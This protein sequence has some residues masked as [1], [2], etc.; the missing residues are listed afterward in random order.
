MAVVTS[1]ARAEP[2]AASVSASERGRLPRGLVAGLLRTRPGV[3]GAHFK[4]HWSLLGEP[5]GVLIMAIPKRLLARAV[6]RNAVRRVAREAWRASALAQAPVAAVLRMTAV[7]PARGNRHRKA[8]VRAELDAAF[9]AMRKRLAQ[10]RQRRAPDA[11]T[12]P[13]AAAP[14]AAPDAAR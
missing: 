9:G 6:D 3:A 10:P 13:G 7:P 2:R 14:G 8:L 12:S 1:S 4:L 5:P 11:G